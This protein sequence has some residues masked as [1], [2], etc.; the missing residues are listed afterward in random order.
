MEEIMVEKSPLGTF[1]PSL[2]EPFRQFG[3]KLADWLA[4]AAEASSG[5]DAYRITMELPGVAEGDINLTV[6]N[7]VVAVKGE[8]KT[9]REETGDTWY[10]SE[11]QYGAFQRSFRVPADADD[12]G[13][14]ADLKDGVLTITI[15]RKKPSDKG[16]KR[17]KISKA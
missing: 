1:W 11:R 7:G 15:P 4:P 17:V 8:K 6:E 10:F 12:S 9:Q 5:E 16:G 13:V 3:G 14:S 2:Y